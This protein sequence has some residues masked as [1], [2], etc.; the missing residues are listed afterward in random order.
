ME[1]LNETSK[2]LRESHLKKKGKFLLMRFTTLYTYQEIIKAPG[3]L[4]EIDEKGIIMIFYKILL[5]T[6][7][8]PDIWKEYGPN[9]KKM[10]VTLMQKIFVEKR[11]FSM[12]TVAS[13]IK[14]ISK[15]SLILH[16]ETHFA[17]T[18][19][20]IIYKLLN[21]ISVNN[22]FFLKSSFLEISKNAEFVGSRQRRI[23]IE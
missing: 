17:L 2:L 3:N 13:F 23:R 16:E 11:Q 19:L 6:I 22:P 20:F 9:E 4:L 8:N 12:E 15:L 1:S 14:L 18:L 21:V 7:K 10:F 5:D